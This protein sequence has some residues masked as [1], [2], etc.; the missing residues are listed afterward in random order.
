[1]T[2]SAFTPLPVKTTDDIRTGLWD[3]LTRQLASAGERV[4]LLT[5]QQASGQL[6]KVSGLI[7]EVVG[8]R[9]QTGQ[10]CLVQGNDSTAVEAEVVGFDR[11]T[12]LLM[13][14]E[15]H[16]GLS[17]G[18]KVT[19][20]GDNSSILVGDPLLG[21][22]ID[23]AGRPLDSKPA[24]AGTANTRLH[25]HPI[26]PLQRYP[27]STPLD[28]GVRSINGLLTIGR[29]QRIGLFAGSGTGKSTLLGMIA[30]NTS[31]DIVV[32]AMIGERGREVGDFIRQNMDDHCLQRSVV[33]AAPA[34]HSPVMRLRA[35]LVAHRVAEHYR[36][37]GHHVLLLMDSLTRYAQ[38][39]RE[40]GLA[41]G[42]PPAA[43]GYPPSA[44]NRIARLVERAGNGYKPTGSLTAFYTVL[45]EGDQDTDPIGE[46][47]KAILDGH[48][49]L[50]HELAISGHYPAID[51]VT[52]VSRTMTQSVSGEHLKMALMFRRLLEKAREGRELKLLGVY[53]PGNDADMDMAMAAEPAMLEYLQQSVNQR[54]P[55]NDSIHQL[56]TLISGLHHGH[57]QTAG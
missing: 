38:A 24:P 23:G 27:V 49:V 5:P 11:S 7:M 12:L 2:G 31:A 51:V 45:I 10:R 28:V 6:I 14:I 48:L 33:V 52:S 8:C 19:P 16:D 32:L 44:F 29:G 47:A 42:E 41:I 21:R 56:K 50:S 39:C 43:R 36:D 22:I 53:Q 20:M 34:D 30:R 13:P 37:T 55:F 35:A 15:Y 57:Q 3:R 17:P 25:D 4:T 1:M 26:N 18:A 40:V 54:Q 46:A 9:M